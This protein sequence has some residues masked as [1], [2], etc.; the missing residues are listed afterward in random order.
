MI[1][2]R[3]G[4]DGAEIE[5]EADSDGQAEYA[6]GE[7]RQAAGGCIAAQLED[8][9]EEKEGDG[10]A[11]QDLVGGDEAHR[12]CLCHSLRATARRDRRRCAS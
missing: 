6:A 10:A 3:F 8:R 4:E 9:E 1:L 11:D 7:I 2:T 12:I 5:S